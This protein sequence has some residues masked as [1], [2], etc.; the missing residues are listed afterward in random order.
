MKGFLSGN[1]RVLLTILLFLLPLQVWGQSKGRGVNL[2]LTVLS[3]TDGQPVIGAAC[4]LTDYGIYDISDEHGTVRL[5]KVPVG[6][7]TLLVQILG[8]EDFQKTYNFQRDSTF[9]IRI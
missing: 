9:T 4:L 3:D 1:F 6:K 7:T 5:E 8:Y 2:K